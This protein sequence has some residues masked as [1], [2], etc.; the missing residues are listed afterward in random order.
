[1]NT[2]AIQSVEL[3]FIINIPLP[4]GVIKMVDYKG[5]DKR[6]GRIPKVF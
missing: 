5:L 3:V 6:L 4:Y 1:M 2:Y